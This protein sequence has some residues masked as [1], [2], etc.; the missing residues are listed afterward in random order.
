MSRSDADTTRAL[1]DGFFIP[2]LF[3]RSFAICDVKKPNLIV[4][5]G[6]M[7]ELTNSCHNHIF[8]Q[9]ASRNTPAD[10]LKKKLHEKN[11]YWTKTLDNPI[12]KAQNTGF[13]PFLFLGILNVPVQVV[14]QCICLTCTKSLRPFFFRAHHCK[15]HPFRQDKCF[16]NSSGS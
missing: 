13:F 8:F 9:P 10:S 16:F 3:S 6:Q 14:L 1:P 5:S 15:F 4:R 7:S 11:N 12:L 2:L